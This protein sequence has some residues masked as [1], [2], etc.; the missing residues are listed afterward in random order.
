MISANE[1]DS[2]WETELETR[3]QRYR[4]NREVPTVDEI[5]QEQVV[6]EGS[7]ATNTKHLQYIMQLSTATP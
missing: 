1:I 2:G 3:Q 7:V 6:G 5:P 4:L